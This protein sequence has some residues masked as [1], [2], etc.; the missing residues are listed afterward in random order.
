MFQQQPAWNKTRIRAEQSCKHIEKDACQQETC[1][2]NAALL[3]GVSAALAMAL[4]MLA[5][6]VNS[7]SAT[8]LERTSR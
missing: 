8:T 2:E 7:A 5:N 4:T 1:I 6:T 3:S